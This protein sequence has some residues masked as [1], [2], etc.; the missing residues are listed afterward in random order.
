MNH[1]PIEPTNPV[2]LDSELSSE[3]DH[4]APAMRVAR[5]IKKY[6]FLN[7]FTLKGIL[8]RNFQTHIWQEAIRLYMENKV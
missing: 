3:S 7:M 8:I 1:H 6:E 4:E 2:N 5:F